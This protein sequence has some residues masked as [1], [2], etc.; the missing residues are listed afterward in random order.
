ML[1]Y[2]PII[3]IIFAQQFVS[4][5]S[6]YIQPD[7]I[8]ENVYPWGTK[9]FSDHQEDILESLRTEMGLYMKTKYM[10]SN[11]IDAI[12][13]E[14]LSLRNLEY[15]KFL[16]QNN[17]QSQFIETFNMKRVRSDGEFRE[18]L[19]SLCASYYEGNIEYNWCHKK[20]ITESHYDKTVHPIDQQI[21]VKTIGTY[22]YGRIDRE[23]DNENE[24]MPITMV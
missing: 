21:I 19:E 9:T 10:N 11:L 22:A 5:V 20:H 13:S 16:I 8:F 14:K 23:I 3:W 15:Q 17:H 1:L 7:N 12:N 4:Y 18:T 6:C 24:D 2:S